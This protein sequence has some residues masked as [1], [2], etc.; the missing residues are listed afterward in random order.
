VEGQRQEVGQVAPL[1]GGTA[2]GWPVPP[3]GVA[4]PWI[5]SISALDSIS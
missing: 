2:R 3:H 5:S 1:P 4:G